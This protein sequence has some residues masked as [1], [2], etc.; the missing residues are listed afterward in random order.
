MYELARFLMDRLEEDG[1]A[2][3]RRVDEGYVENETYKGTPFD[4]EQAG[5]RVLAQTQIVLE[6]VREERSIDEGEALDWTMG[7]QSARGSVIHFLIQPYSNH[8]EFREEW[9]L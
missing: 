4:A 5:A 2:I 3:Q 1:V 8:P 9:R 7:G 6:W